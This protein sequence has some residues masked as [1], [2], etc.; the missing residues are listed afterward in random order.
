MVGFEAGKK[1]NP[2]QNNPQYTQPE[3][4]RQP[5]ITCCGLLKVISVLMLLEGS[6]LIF[7]PM[8]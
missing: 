2:F 5:R 8:A 4:G 6:T 7:S 3:T 1:S